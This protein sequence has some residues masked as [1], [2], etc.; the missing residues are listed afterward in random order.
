MTHFL[1]YWKPESAETAGAH[2]DLLEHSASDQYKRVEPG[3]T[4][5]IVT[6]SDGGLWLI[7]RIVVGQVTDQAGAERRFGTDDLW[8]AKYHIIAVKGTEIPVS[9]LDIKNLAGSLR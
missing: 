5:W 6:F 7:G 4:V 9:D 1:S 3:D 8:D 2:D